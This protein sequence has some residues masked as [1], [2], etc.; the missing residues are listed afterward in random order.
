[1]ARLL[2]N[3]FSRGEIAPQQRVRVD[4][5][6]YS[7]GASEITNFFVMPQGGL[8]RRPPLR[9][10][11]EVGGSA[12]GAA[13]PAV[14]VD[15]VYSRD[16]AYVIEVGAGWFR[17][18]D[19]RAR[20]VIAQGGSPYTIDDLAGLRWAQSGNWVYF[21]CR[22]KAPHVLKRDGAAWYFEVFAAKNG[23]WVGT[24]GEDG[25]ELTV[26][27]GGTIG[28]SAPYFTRAME[29]RMIELNYRQE[30]REVSESAPA[31]NPSSVTS[32]A[33]EVGGEWN[34]TTTGGWTGTV[35]IEKRTAGGAWIAIY[36]KSRPDS[37]TYAN[38]D[39]SGSE[40]DVNVEMRVI[41]D[42][43]SGGGGFTFSVSSFS[44]TNIF[45]I[46]AVANSQR[47]VA[48]WIKGDGEVG[49]WFITGK[50]TGDWR[51]GAWGGSC[52]W[53]A[54]VAFYQG[55]LAFA[56]TDAQPLTI[57]MSKID[58]FVN[59]GTSDPAR[60]DD[61]ITATLMSGDVDGIHSLLAIQE[62]FAFTGA[63]EWR[64]K[65]AG[66]GGAITPSA[67]VAHRQDNVGSA[68][69]QPVLV[70]GQ[71]I[72]VQRHGTQVHAMKYALDMDGYSGSEISV[73]SAHMFEGARR[74]TRMKHQRV[75]DDLIWCVRADG[76][77]AVCTYVSEH[78]VVA[79]AG[80]VTDGA[81]GDVCVVPGADRDEVW[82]LVR[83]EGR[84]GVEVLEGHGVSEYRDPGGEYES[85]LKTLRLNIDQG[86]AL[87]SAKKAIHRC[88]IYTMETSG[89]AWIGPAA[90]TKRDRMRMYSWIIGYSGGEPFG[91]FDVMLDSGFERGAGI[92]I[93]KDDVAPMTILGVAPQITVG[94]EI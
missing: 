56:A 11:G 80:V 23:P 17:V 59:F 79:W 25:V 66:D 7:L 6:A 69:I 16:E 50:A 85:I 84:W 41:M 32:E 93:V 43:T 64:L 58:D 26:A 20:R 75:P 48:T 90:D 30:R 14:L 38:L 10:L 42:K 83:R 77:A 1:M 21:S 37:G 39:V 19:V 89:V 72:Y 63:G 40:T 88:I 65:G 82:C 24:R 81:I 51:L 55:R 46:D 73:M 49:A 54:A 57:W 8:R 35:T 12:G 60:D 86:G 29:G 45:R 52:G 2:G 34:L 3:S 9:R 74:I 13:M 87:L 33:V 76:T 22:G 31:G 15:F 36:T 53:P 5:A 70:D 4:L 68:A 71:P 91:E 62:L 28:A 44:K 18:W 27:R 47:A 61:A 67:I 94:G 78:D 92:Q